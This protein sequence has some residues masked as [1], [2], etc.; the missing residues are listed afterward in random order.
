MRKRQIILKSI[1]TLVILINFLESASA[2]S[3]TLLN[4]SYDPT[5]ELFEEYN[6]YFTNYWKEKK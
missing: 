1:L 6:K 2:K 5:R 3:V 4:V